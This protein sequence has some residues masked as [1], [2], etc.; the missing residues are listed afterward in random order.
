MK[1]QLLRPRRTSAALMFSALPFLVLPILALLYT[2]SFVFS[3][4]CLATW[5]LSERAFGQC[6]RSQMCL[7]TDVPAASPPD[8]YD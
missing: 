8:D 3:L 1:Y 2:S 5:S 4:L 7:R 6:P